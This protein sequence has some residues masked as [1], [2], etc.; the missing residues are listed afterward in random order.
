MGAQ[1]LRQ[2]EEAPMYERPVPPPEDPYEVRT[3]GPVAPVTPV[4]P[5]TPVGSSYVA[6]AYNY[7]A[8]QVI[9]FVV[10]VINVVIAIRFVMKALGASTVSAFVS[11][12]YAVSDPLVAPFQG[13]FS[14]NGRGYYV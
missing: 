11:F 9:W 3:V 14:T 5:V 1:R 4:T 6:P 12:I 13:I 2:E 8:I 10:A 7:R